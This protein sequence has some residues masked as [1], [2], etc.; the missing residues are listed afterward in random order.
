MFVINSLCQLNMRFFSSP[1]NIFSL[2]I[3]GTRDSNRRW[4]CKIAFGLRWWMMDS[5]CHTCADRSNSK[6]CQLIET[7]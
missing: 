6:H 1:G 2:F 7:M 5:M 4:N 3:I